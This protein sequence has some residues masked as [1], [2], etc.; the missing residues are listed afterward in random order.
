MKITI[1]DFEHH[2]LSAYTE[3]KAI[4]EAYTPYLKKLRE[5]AF[6]LF[7]KGLALPA[8]RDENYQHIDISKAFNDTY[9]LHYD[10]EKKPETTEDMLCDVF[11]EDEVLT[12]TMVNGWVQNGLHELPSGVILGSLVEAYK[13]YP[14]LIENYFYGIVDESE[15]LAALNTLFAQDGFFVYVP[16]KV[17]L[18][19]VVK[20]I[21]IVSATEELLISPRSLIVVGKQAS[22]KFLLC[23]QSIFP[24]YFANNSVLALHAES[25]AQVEFIRLQDTHNKSYQLTSTY[26]HQATDSH[27]KSNT[28]TLHG[29]NVRNNIFAVLAGEGAYHEM[30][31]LFLVDKGQHVDN[32]T[33]IEHA[34]SHGTSNERFNGILDDFSTGAFSGRILVDKDAQQTNARQSNHNI[35]LTSDAKMNTK[36]QLEI[37]ADDVKCSHGAVV[38]Q[39]NEEALFY[40]RQRGIYKKDARLLLLSAFADE[41]VSQ[42]TIEKVTEEVRRLVSRRL[43]G[44]WS[45]CN[46]CQIKC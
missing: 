17:E 27:V 25:S 6:R 34:K 4:I 16:D 24:A 7:E 36:P 26:I 22:V 37:Y 23:E 39:L 29:G 43:G 13:K 44:D 35:L 19:K 11:E 40:L 9:H 5:T 3:N 33:F 12:V 28:I 2:F 38:G 42:I 46:K 15:P 31:G 1:P 30:L 18:N 20:L 21:N 32:F 41:I 45:R 14:A 10:K 8:K